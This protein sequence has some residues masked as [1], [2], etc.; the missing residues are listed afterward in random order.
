MDRQL[1]HFREAALFGCITEASLRLGISQPAI[2]KSI[3]ALE[4][5]YETQLIERQGRGIQLTQA[6]KLLLERVERIERELNS[7][8][9]DLK[10]LDDEPTLL[11]FG[12]G[13]AWEPIIT[14]VL[15]RFCLENP[16]AQLA[17]KSGPIS[18]LMTP[19]LQGDL[20]FALGGED[21]GLLVSNNELSFSPFTSSHLC[22]LVRRDHPLA[23]Q[24]INDLQPLTHFP[25][26][27]FQQ[28]KQIL[29]HINQLLERQGASI[30]NYAIET[31]FLNMAIKLVTE[32]DYLLCI[33]S[34]L[35][36]TIRNDDLSILNLNYSI[37]HYHLGAWHRD[38][39]QTNPLAA[40]FL[41]RLRKHVHLMK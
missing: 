9:Q 38:L 3:K 16:S 2:S 29:N 28:S 21:G 10:M 33:S 5:K 24:A 30:V 41:R 31:E 23:D 12:A 34:H 22:L 39:S 25:W 37:W 13:P 19:L 15:P 7:Y 26:I 4:T 27:A 11:R 6:G 14:H 36:R 1:I 32:S 40:D 17:I 8:Q 35:A 18:E 20:D